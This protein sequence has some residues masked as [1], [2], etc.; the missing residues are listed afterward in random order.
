M[1][2]NSDVFS[3]YTAFY[4]DIF[5]GIIKRCSF[6]SNVSTGN[7]TLSGGQNGLIGNAVRHINTHLIEMSSIHHIFLLIRRIFPLEPF[8]QKLPCFLTPDIR[9]VL[10][11]QKFLPNYIMSLIIVEFN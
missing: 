3:I 9:I 4:C 5:K 6:F 2:K 8:S 7:I 11:P 1:N 10:N